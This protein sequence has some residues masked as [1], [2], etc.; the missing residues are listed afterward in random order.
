M[1]K[2]GGTYLTVDPTQTSGSV[3]DLH[4]IWATRIPVVVV[5]I[6]RLSLRKRYDV[7][8]SNGTEF[9]TGRLERFKEV[10]L[11]AG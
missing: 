7:R 4:R 10:R 5:R 2:K 6:H 3:V 11:G 9:S 8:A 1:I